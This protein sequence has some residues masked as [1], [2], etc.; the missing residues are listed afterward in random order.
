[1]KFKFR[2]IYI[3]IFVLVIFIVCIAA[4]Y[5]SKDPLAQFIEEQ[6]NFEVD[7]CINKNGEIT[8]KFGC[9]LNYDDSEYIEYYS[10]YC[11]RLVLH[12]IR[13]FPRQAKDMPQKVTI[14]LYDICTE[15]YALILSVSG[16]GLIE[17]QWDK[18]YE[19]QLADHVDY[20]YYNEPAF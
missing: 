9:Q 4:F 11:A 7:K 8:V 13:V 18:L 3:I 19:D 20:Y 12:T 6:T 5:L 2:K 17:T 1:M 14:E 16:K 15:Q 10:Q